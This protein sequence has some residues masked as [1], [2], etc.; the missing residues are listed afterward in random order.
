LRDWNEGKSNV[1]KLS[2]FM[3]IALGSTFLSVTAAFADVGWPDHFIRFPDSLGGSSGG[4]GFIDR[5]P[6]SV[7]LDMLESQSELP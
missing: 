6:A 4:G 1:Q 5:V 3:G 7:A 2:F